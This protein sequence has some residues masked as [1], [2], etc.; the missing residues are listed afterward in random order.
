M[1]TLAVELGI[2][3]HQGDRDLFV[4]RGSARS[5]RRGPPSGNPC[6]SGNG[7]RR[8]SKRL[9]SRADH[10]PVSISKPARM[11]MLSSPMICAIID[12]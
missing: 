9:H 2:R 10:L 3:Q 5:R 12:S 7:D 11:S 8:F 4:V 6:E 1:I